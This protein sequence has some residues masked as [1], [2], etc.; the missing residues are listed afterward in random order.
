MKWLMVL[1]ITFVIA[2]MFLYEWPKMNL[3][4]KREKYTFVVLSVISWALAILLL[5]YPEMPGPTDM[6]DRIYKPL[7]KMLE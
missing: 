3:K 2:L 4:Q 6:I 5:F 1:G 7:G